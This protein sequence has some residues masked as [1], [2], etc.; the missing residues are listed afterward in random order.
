M[1]RISIKL[2]LNET[3][4]VEMFGDC[5]ISPRMCIDSVLVQCEYKNIQFISR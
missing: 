5:K 3:I 4:R 1:Y 2:L